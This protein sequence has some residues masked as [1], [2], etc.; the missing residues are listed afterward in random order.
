MQILKDLEELQDAG[1]I[2]EE[3]AQ[4][5]KL[6][7][8]NK[9]GRGNNR[10]FAIFGTLGA[11]LVG[12]GIILIIAHN[13]GQLSKP[14]KTLFAF[15]PLILG[16]FAAAYALW[17][18]ENSI[19]WREGSAAFI[20]FGL[21]AAISLISQIY[22]ISGNLA[23]FILTWMLLALPM[24]YVLRS[25][26][27]GIFYLMGITYYACELGYF[28]A[29]SYDRWNWYPLLFLG[30]LPHFWIL[31]KHHFR[32][33]FLNFYNWLIP[34]SLT[35]CL[36]ILGKSNEDLLLLAY[37]SLF[38]IFYIVG[39]SRFLEKVSLSSNGLQIVGAFGSVF[40]LLMTSFREVWKDIQTEHYDMESQ[41]FIA[42]SVL[43]LIGLAL[44][45]YVLSAS[46]WKK[47]FPFGYIWLVFIPIF[48]LGLSTNLAVIIINLMV[49]IIGVSTVKRGADGA[50]IGLLN[51]GLIIIMVLISCRFFDANLSFVLRGLMFVALGLTFFFVNYW[52]IKKMKKD[53]A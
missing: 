31:L 12:M 26:I 38:G 32:S 8:K 10:L 36:G 34:L 53:E 46:H 15:V 5:I 18:E 52:M 48:F 27:V 44:L 51:F 49:L 33:N 37:L 40:I 45:A 35:I 43:S 23:S 39:K 4:Q 25:S 9:D 50:H 22:N 7:Y 6:Y 13:W 14:L 47:V 3:S 11:I 2:S 17:K 29:R 42:F 24:V 19:A 16:Q 28:N 30:I 20:F 21:G 1:L 41:E